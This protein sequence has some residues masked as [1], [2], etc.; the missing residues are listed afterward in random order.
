M[1]HLAFNED[2]FVDIPMAASEDCNV[3]SYPVSSEDAVAQ[4]ENPFP[5]VSFG[6]TTQ[7]I[8]APRDIYGTCH[9]DISITLQSLGTTYVNQVQDQADSDGV[10]LQMRRLR[11]QSELV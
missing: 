8:V 6:L 1:Q 2:M 3:A 10:C 4:S 11:C 7:L 5:C 9:E